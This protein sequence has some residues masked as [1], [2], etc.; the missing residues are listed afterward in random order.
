MEKA[1]VSIVV[2]TYNGAQHL[3]Q[4]LDSL[5]NQTYRPIEIIISDDV[6]SD[7]SFEIAAHYADKYDFI[8]CKQN[9]ENKGINENMA[10]TFLLAKGKYIAP[11]DQDDVWMPEKIEKLVALIETSNVDIA[12]CDALLTDEHLKPTGEKEL[13][14]YPSFTEKDPKYILSQNSISGHSMLFRKSLLDFCY[15][16]A[17]LP[18]YYDWWLAVTAL[19][20][21]GVKYLNEPLVLFR[22]HQN[23]STISKKISK[24]DLLN[25]FLGYYY[26]FRKH[27]H[28]SND[29][30]AFLNQLIT[31]NELKHKKSYVFSHAF[32]Y[33]KN[34]KILM[35]MRRKNIFSNVFF[36]L[37][38]AKGVA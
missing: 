17:S 33:L 19:T 16:F 14:H 25:I 28:L 32:F 7:S 21:N 3:N 29:D 38:N 6:S 15:P 24:K 4:Q 35:R 31:I 27:P 36:I 23:A 9:I 5:I 34:Y 2:C 8:S 1:L 10:Q 11:C 13:D 30:K 18:V 37:K 22:R 26:E 12:Y 20:K